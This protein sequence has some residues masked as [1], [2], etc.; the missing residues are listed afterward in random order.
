M[1]TSTSFV[2][3]AKPI[4]PAADTTAGATAKAVAATVEKRIFVKLR[5]VYRG[6][7]ERKVA[8]EGVFAK[9]EVWRVKGVTGK[10]SRKTV[11]SKSIEDEE[12]V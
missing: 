3:R 10:K 7:C 12:S 11:Q 6:R 5:T 8:F 4:W 1:L 2:P 9:E